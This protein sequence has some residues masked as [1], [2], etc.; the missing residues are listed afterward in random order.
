MLKTFDNKGH[1]AGSSRSWVFLF[2]FFF[3]FFK[4]YFMLSASVL[5]VKQLVKPLNVW[6]LSILQN[7]ICHLFLSL[8]WYLKGISTCCFRKHSVFAEDHYGQ[9]YIKVCA[10]ASKSERVYC[11]YWFPMFVIAAILT[12]LTQKGVPA[13]SA[14]QQCTL[15]DNVG[16]CD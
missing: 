5:A 6:L 12:A 2:F 13:A 14:E 15:Y 8:K 3:C 9:I 1:D 10:S 11:T 4:N 16:R 7:S